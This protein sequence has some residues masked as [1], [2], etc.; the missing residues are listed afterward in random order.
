MSWLWSIIINCV[1]FFHLRP[2]LG[3]GKANCV[4]EDWAV[5]GVTTGLAPET[6]VWVVMELDT[7]GTAIDT[8]LFE[9]GSEN[10]N[11]GNPSDDEI[12]AKSS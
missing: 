7:A 4:G 11:K 9:G 12:K 8:V 3:S 10:K 1:I 2:P 6:V 5:I